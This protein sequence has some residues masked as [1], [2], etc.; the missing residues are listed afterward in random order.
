VKPQNRNPNTE[1]K[2]KSETR[3]PKE[4]RNSGFE[5]HSAFG[6]RNSDSADALLFEFADAVTQLRRPLEILPLDRPPELTLQL[7]DF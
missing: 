5:L 3:D 6:F 4:I 2:S 1:R 7:F